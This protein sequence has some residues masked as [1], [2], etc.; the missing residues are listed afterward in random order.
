MS[1]YDDE[2]PRRHR[3]RRH[4]PAYEE[5]EVVE[6]RTGR[7]NRNINRHTEMIP[8]PRDSS[9]SSIEEVQRTYLPG[10]GEYV[11]RKTTVRDKSGR[12][13]SVDRADY[14]KSSRRKYT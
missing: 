10:G 6:T 13:R 8:R 12:A 2:E 11:K 4:R 14:Y 1:Y 9:S 5:E 3:S 7:D